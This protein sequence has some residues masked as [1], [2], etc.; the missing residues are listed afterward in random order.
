MAFTDVEYKFKKIG[1]NVQIGRT[2][3]FR[4]PEEV[5]IGDN[6]IIDEFC[7]FT[8]A[9]KIGNYV[10]IAPSCSII[11]GKES[12]LIMSDYSG[13]AAGTRVLCGSD[14]YVNGPFT[15]PTI[16]AEFRPNTKKGKVVV[17]KHAIIGTNVVIHPNVK[18]GEGA[19][20][21]S[22]SLVT[23]DL[24]AWQVYAGIPAKIIKAR[25]KELILDGENRF[26]EYLK[27]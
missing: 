25:N 3:Y 20:V 7:Y 1:K 18:I 14:D 4:Y 15:N 6:V 16:P 12:E 9:V 10:H 24:E 19:A 22:L 11:G 2:V 5:E 21:G 23:K 17:A 26:L 13:L 8:T 27:K